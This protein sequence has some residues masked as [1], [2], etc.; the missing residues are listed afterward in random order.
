MQSMILANHLTS[1]RISDLFFFAS[2]CSDVHSTCLSLQ[3]TLQNGGLSFQQ[4]RA[5]QSEGLANTGNKG[6]WLIGSLGLL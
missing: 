1:R 6:G 5:R 4:P 2:A 3:G